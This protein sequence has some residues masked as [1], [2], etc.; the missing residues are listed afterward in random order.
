VVPKLIYCIINIFGLGITVFSDY[1]Y[2]IIQCFFQR[3]CTINVF[4][5]QL[6]L[7]LMILYSVIKMKYS[8]YMK[9]ESCVKCKL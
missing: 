4:Y 5:R 3:V 1:I 9:T 2:I 7:F 6:Y 8:Y